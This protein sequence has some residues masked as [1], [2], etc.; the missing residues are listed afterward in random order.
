MEPVEPDSGEVLEVM[1]AAGAVAFAAQPPPA[2]FG[3][4]FLRDACGRKAAEN[5]G[6][7][8]RPRVGIGRTRSPELWRW[9]GNG[10]V[11]RPET[12]SR[13]RGVRMGFQPHAVVN[14]VIDESPRALRLRREGGLRHPRG[15]LLL[16]SL[17][18]SLRFVLLCH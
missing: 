10:Q 6:T 12:R 3:S 16:L 18:L 5:R 11:R 4:F 15:E 14:C 13:K 17:S 9:I 7:T 8:Q 2:H 1:V